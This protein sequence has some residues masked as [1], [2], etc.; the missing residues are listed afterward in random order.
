MTHSI[1]RHVR[2]VVGLLVVA[3]L[4]ANE[5]IT[6]GHVFDTK[7]NPIA[8]ADVLLA[9]SSGVY[10]AGRSDDRGYFRFAHRPFGRLGKVLLICANRNTVHVSPQAG[11]AIIRSSYTIGA[12]RSR[13]P[14][15]P[16]DLGWPAEVPPSCPSKP[17][18][19]AG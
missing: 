15:T 11:S 7:G 4:V 3:I 1:R 8:G 13:F 12:E 16:G 14:T 19:R 10:A 17:V 5:A 18:S 6:R 2:W 9:D